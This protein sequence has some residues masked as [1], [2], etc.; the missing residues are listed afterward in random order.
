VLWRFRQSSAFNESQAASRL[1]HGYRTCGIRTARI[2]T[3]N[4]MRSAHSELVT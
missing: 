4:C 3:L 1:H 2:S